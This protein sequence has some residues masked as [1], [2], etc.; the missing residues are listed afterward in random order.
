MAEATRLEHTL[1][2]SERERFDAR[3]VL[4][5]CVSGYT[6]A[7]PQRRFEL[8]LAAQSAPL[9]GSPELFA[10]MLDKLAANAVDFSRG[11]EPVRIALEREGEQVQISMSNAGPLLPADMQ[12]RLFESMVSVRA[13][14]SGDPHLGLGLYIAR[15]I[16]EFHGGRIAA[17]NRDDGSGVIV[18]LRFP[19]RVAAYNTGQPA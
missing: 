15:L 18:T 3:L 13:Q 7:Y 6:S 19:L 12:G 5:G 10:Q 17:T 11:D 2:Q 9:E 1:R 4:S 16:A 8:R 14:A